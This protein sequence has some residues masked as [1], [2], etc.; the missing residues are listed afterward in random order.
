[1]T[2]VSSATLTESKPICSSIFNFYL[3]S[4][5]GFFVC[6]CILTRQAVCSRPAMIYHHSSNPFFLGTT[7]ALLCSQPPAVVFGANNQSHPSNVN[8]ADLLDLPLPPIQPT[9]PNLIFCPGHNQILQTVQLSKIFPDDKT[10]VDRPSRFPVDELLKSFENLTQDRGN[11]TKTALF[12]WVTNHFSAEGQDLS[13][14]NITD[15]KPDLPFFSR[16]P[17]P[18]IRG[19]LKIVHSYWTKLA[20]NSVINKECPT[21]ESSQIP[22]NVCSIIP[23]KLLL[24][25]I[26]S[27][28]SLRLLFYCFFFLQ[29]GLLH[30]EIYS[31]AKFTL[32]NFLDEI[33]RFGFIPNGARLYYLNRSQPPLFTQM[34]HLYVTTTNDISLLP[35]ALPL[36]EK[37]ISW[38]H[39]NRLESVNS[40]F[41][42]RKHDVY[43]YRVKNSAPRPE[44][45]HI[46]FEVVWGEIKNPTDYL[47]SRNLSS[48]DRDLLY[49]QLASGAESGLDYSG[50][51]WAKVPTADTV[52]NA[53]ILRTLNIVNILPIDL[54]SIMY[55][56]FI[57]LS[58][59]YQREIE[60]SN[61]KVQY[62]SGRAKDLKEA[63]VD[64]FW[65]ENRLGFYDF[66]QTSNS[67][68]LI[69]SPASYAPYWAGIYPDSMIND[70]AI[71]QKALAGPAYLATRFNGSVPA[72]LIPTGLQWDFPNVWPPHV[73]IVLQAYKNLPES[74]SKGNF[75]SFIEKA[76]NFNYLPSNHFGLNEDELPNQPKSDGTG[77]VFNNLTFGELGNV[78]N[79]KNVNE[80][81]W[82][83]GMVE[84]IA[85]RLIASSFCSWYAT[86]GSVPGVVPE[87]SA[88][89]LDR[90]GSIGKSG[91]MFEKF[92]VTNVNAAGGGGEYSVQDGFGWTNGIILT[93]SHWL[94]DKL[95]T[96]PICPGHEIFDSILPE[97]LT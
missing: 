13:P 33:E 5:L 7:F 36:V 31:L 32:L 52:I 41:T 87:L 14:A 57:A 30:S 63:I 59:L 78:G 1:M 6:V 66:N 92:N 55:K 53:P 84:T 69:W 70:E 28:K 16:V 96:K 48:N 79:L 19:W 62:W 27:N 24:G 3:A 10:F 35:R 89:S 23:G 11:F 88:E 40:P 9:C 50:S 75:T 42:S 81:S 43:Q 25:K 34:L 8:I 44:G 91:H 38:W 56:N 60:P 74:I 94:A 39:E 67:R 37:E 68:S 82:S 77:I 71:A 49:S 2:C 97:S 65:D 47:P 95:D 80:K 29:E 15:F 76:S 61:E 20:R 21:C 64:L 58:E 51:R 18:S 86:G 17:D 26:S 72:S 45:Y 4:L 85:H 93:F 46:D 73:Y 22:L 83:E 12:E 90:A 54:N